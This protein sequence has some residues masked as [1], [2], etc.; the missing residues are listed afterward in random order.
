M[1]LDKLLP[2]SIK[3]RIASYGMNKLE[4]DNPFLKLLTRK[5]PKPACMDKT[6]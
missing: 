2:G 5:D 6:A 4:T 3:T 1:L